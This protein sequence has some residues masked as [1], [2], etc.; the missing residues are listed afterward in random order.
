MVGRLKRDFRRGNTVLGG[1][2][3]STRRNINDPGLDTLLPQH[4]EAVGSDF[5]IN[6]K[7]RMYSL[8][9]QYAF[10]TVGGDTLAISRLQ[11][12]PAHYFQRPDRHSK[13]GI[14]SDGL[15]PTK[16]V[17][18]GAGGYTRF[19]KD[20]GDWLFETAINFRTPGFEVNDL[21]FNSRSDYF[22]HNLNFARSVTKPNK[23]QRNMFSIL[24]A[25]RQQNFDGDFTDGQV[26]AYHGMTFPNYWYAN[27]FVMYR[28]EA[29]DD[30]LL[31]G[32]PV[33][34]RAQNIY[35]STDVAT[36]SRNKLVLETNPF[37][38]KNAEGF[39]SY[40]LNLYA[41][42][43]PASNISVNFGPSYSYGA[44][45]AQFV[46]GASYDDPGATAFF[47]RRY[48]FSSVIQKTVSFDTR[49]QWTFTPTLTLEMFMQPL[50]GSVDY[51]DFKEFEAPRKLDKRLYGTKGSTIDSVTS[52]RGR[53]T[54][55][56]VDADGTGGGPSRTFDNPDF[57][58][59]S[60]IGN[61]VLRWEYMPGSTMYLV[62][63][64]SRNGSEGRGDFD[65]GRDYSQLFRTN[66]RN[67][68]LVK[69]NYWLG[70]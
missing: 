25:Q 31:R 27:A 54:Q 59:R 30:R 62:W 45:G 48:V 58:F 28:P 41:R 69:V 32:G 17:M 13:D 35:V 22:W 4:A 8:I 16:D 37:L 29:S 52:A 47:G 20:G 5:N 24:G 2:V 10:S 49:L 56:T 66:P 12:A 53:V 46:P 3:T 51:F 61:A 36:D 67:Y 14:L 44:S 50:V 60:L 65:F 42:F 40:G 70:R 1:I 21:A 34:R 7:N 19:A 18:R 38:Q 57:I 6:F 39:K 68:F 15:D 64:Q 11:R 33:V 43:K 9:G 63:Q 26:H 55:Y 23:Y